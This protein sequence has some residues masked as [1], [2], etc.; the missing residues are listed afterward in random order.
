MNK[1][2]Y[3]GHFHNG[4][5]HGYGIQII[6]DCEIRGQCTNSMYTIL[7]IKNINNDGYV[8]YLY[9]GQLMNRIKNGSG[10]LYFKNGTSYIGAFKNNKFSNSQKSNQKLNQ[11]RNNMNSKY[12]QNKNDSGKP[13]SSSFCSRGST[14]IGLG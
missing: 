10:I 6:N 5:K 9:N 4:L 3:K 8:E 7:P 13:S 12:C 1:K 14:T 2:L 11:N